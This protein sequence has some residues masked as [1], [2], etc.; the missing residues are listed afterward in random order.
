MFGQFRKLLMPRLELCSAIDPDAQPRLERLNAELYEFYHSE[1]TPQYFEAAEHGN[2]VWRPE[3]K[4]HW[5]LKNAIPKGSRVVDLGCGTDLTCRNLSDRH[6]KSTGVDWSEEQ[7]ARNREQTPDHTFMSST[8]Y[9]A[10]LPEGS[11]DIAISLYTIEHLVWPHRLLDEMYRLVRPEGLIGI[12]TPPFRIRDTIKSFDFG[13]SARPFKD[14]LRTGRLLDAALHLYQ[15]RVTYRAY[16]KR[17]HPRGSNRHRFLIN[18]E[19]ICLRSE[20]WF[21]DADAVYLTDT[22]EM[23]AHLAAKGAIRIKEWPKHSYILLRKAA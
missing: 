7:I 1:F 18:L 12:L 9:N 6:I 4:A 22:R 16:L 3:L 23:V 11:F 14:K 2:F 20:N 17:N 8:L 10:P 15:H 19:P 21:P 5:H 13:L